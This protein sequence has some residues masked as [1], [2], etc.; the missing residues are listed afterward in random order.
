MEWLTIDPGMSKQ[1]DIFRSIWVSERPTPS[2]PQR[3]AFVASTFEARTFHSLLTYH[4]SKA[5]RKLCLSLSEIHEDTVYR[6]K[7]STPEFILEEGKD[8]CKYQTMLR[9]IIG[10][11][12]KFVRRI[13]NPV[14]KSEKTHAFI[15]DFPHW[16]PISM[17]LNSVGGQ[18][19]KHG[20][21]ESSSM[22]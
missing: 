2:S 5:L 19:Q 10:E 22:N 7:K 3:G 18:R 9:C 17:D 15:T 1:S 20:V 11:N 16:S 13:T 14:T 8:Y 6:T 12:D 4:Y 21:E